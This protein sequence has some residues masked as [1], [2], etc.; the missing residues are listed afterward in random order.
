MS[1]TFHNTIHR[2]PGFFGNSHTSGNIQKCF[3]EKYILIM[4]RR[5]LAKANLFTE[6]CAIV[7][8]KY[9][10]VNF[11]EFCRLETCWKM[12]LQIGYSGERTFRTNQ[13]TSFPLPA[14]S[15]A[16][17]RMLSQATAGERVHG[18]C[19]F[20]S[21]Y[22]HPRCSSGALTTAG[23]GARAGAHSATQW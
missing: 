22:S 3:V 18:A 8:T 10:I 16:P 11:I 19:Y 20:L 15:R 6:N 12:S 5:T 9:Y 2:L 7:W 23:V 17:S 21:H 1:R 4:F 13:S 14:C